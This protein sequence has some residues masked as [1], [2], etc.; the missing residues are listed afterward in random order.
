MTK[1]VEINIAVAVKVHL[2][3][4]LFPY[5]SFLLSFLVLVEPIQGFL[6][7][8]V[9]DCAATILVKELEG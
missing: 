7:L 1:L 9:V 2:V 4:K 8:Q 5:S 3:N 6:D